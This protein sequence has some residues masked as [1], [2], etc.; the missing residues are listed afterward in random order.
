MPS[1]Q[2]SGRFI[3]ELSRKRG[4]AGGCVWKKYLV[5]KMGRKKVREAL[6]DS[7]VTVYKG[8]QLCPA[9]R[10]VQTAEWQQR[11]LHFLQ[12]SRVD[13]F[14]GPLLCWALS[15][16][17]GISGI[18]SEPSWHCAK[19]SLGFFVGGARW[20]LWALLCCPLPENRRWHKNEG[21][22]T[23]NETIRFFGEKIIGSDQLQ[24]QMQVF[25]CVSQWRALMKI[26]C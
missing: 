2:P 9:P 18:I 10:K 11:F 3:T 1:C 15:D 17:L 16:T 14:P 20:E 7:T 13:V 21:S 22:F 25:H 5:P 8:R 6:T 4:G 23:I 24:V 26:S 12:F 19:F